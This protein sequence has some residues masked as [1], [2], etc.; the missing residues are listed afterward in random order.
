[1]NSYTSIFR[2]GLLD[3][4]HNYFPDLLYNSSRFHTVQD[5]LQYIQG[6]ART[7][8]NPFEQG[9]SAYNRYMN[10]NHNHSHQNTVIQ[11]PLTQIPVTQVAQDI[12]GATVDT[13]IRQRTTTVYP[14]A[15]R[16]QRVPISY[17]FTEDLI[18][19]RFND[20]TGGMNALA[21]LFNIALNPSSMI[22]VPIVPTNQQIDAATTVVTPTT[23]I[24]EPCA[25]CQDAIEANT[26]SR[27]INRCHHTFHQS[28]IDTW[29]Q[30][31]V[32]CPI[33]RTDIRGT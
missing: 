22:D 3:D 20:N 32:T 12:S 19:D 7:Q 6:Q 30:S 17:Y 8:F 2:V 33:C 11:P 14:P 18:S 10:H 26:R 4:L 29:F 31:S 16:R 15:P 9:Q 28:C 24:S 5:V 13:P 27:R 21:S 25:I 1:M 23:A